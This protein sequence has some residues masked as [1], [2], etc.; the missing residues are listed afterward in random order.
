MKIIS[1]IS[2][3][4]FLLKVTKNE[5]A[6]LLGEYSFYS[7]KDAFVEQ[8]IKLE[9]DVV[10]S[11]IYAKHGEVKDFQKDMERA[12]EQLMKMHSALET[13]EK[14]ANVKLDKQSK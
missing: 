11:D 12:K 2:E 10:I 13:I 4:H 3:E 1:R 7:I 9:S 6:N 8:A 5:L 14:K